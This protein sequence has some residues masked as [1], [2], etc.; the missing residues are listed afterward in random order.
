MLFTTT[1]NINASFKEEDLYKNLETLDLRHH[2][3]GETVQPNIIDGK[4]KGVKVVFKPT[5]AYLANCIYLKHLRISYNYL[6][7]VPVAIAYLT[8]LLKL[9]I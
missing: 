8:N 1:S 2:E 4:K 3:F 7:S 5:P 9:D 6:G